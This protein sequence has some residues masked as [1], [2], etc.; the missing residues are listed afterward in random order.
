MEAEINKKVV[1]DFF[2]AVAAGDLARLREMTTDDMTWW[3]AP[4]TIFS[5]THDKAAWLDMIATMLDGAAGPFALTID[6]MTAEEDRVSLTARGN[7]PLKNGRIY[8]SHYHLLVRLRGRMIAAVKE[9]ADSYH[10]GK[11]FGFPA[12]LGSGS[13]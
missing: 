13:A 8:A 1:V 3:I 10:V 11:T 5:G 6:E 9:Y 7:M 12:E 4:T 2:D